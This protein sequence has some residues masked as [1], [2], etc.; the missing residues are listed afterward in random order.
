MFGFSRLWKVLKLDIDAEKVLYFVYCGPENHVSDY[1][2]F[3]M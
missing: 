2:I 1:I 3:V